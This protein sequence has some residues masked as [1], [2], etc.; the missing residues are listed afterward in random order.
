MSDY[1]APLSLLAILCAIAL[2]FK[3]NINTGLIALGMALPLGQ[4]LGG[5]SAREIIALW[6]IQ[7]FVTLCGV[8]LLFSIAKANDTLS[9]L[10]HYAISLVGGRARF[11][12]WMIFFLA[13][14]L[15]AIGPGNIAVCA[16]LGSIAMAVADE[17][18]IP[19]IMMG[20][21]LVSGANAGGLSPFAPTGI[22][23]NTLAFETMGI[24]TGFYLWLSNA[25]A[26]LLWVLFLFPF[27]GGFKLS[28]ARMQSN[29]E[30]PSF[31]AK[32]GFTL[33]AIVV[34]I[35]LV[36]GLKMDVGLCSFSLSALLLLGK[37]A[38]EKPSIA[39]IPWGTLLLVSGTAILIE[40]SARLGGISLITSALQRFMNPATA[41]PLY[42]FIAA[43]ISFFASSSGVV[44]PMLIRTLPELLLQLPELSGVV[45]TGTI[46]Y[47]AHIMT[48]SPFSTLG[49]LAAASLSDKS[50]RQLFFKQQL[51]LS[52]IGVPFAVLVALLLSRLLPIV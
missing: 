38:P 27:L 25:L 10:A 2:S 39:G 7:L 20:V 9:L 49:A 41:A 35:V 43:I 42:A 50:D 22:I 4:L 28:M 13:A 12:P 29:E 23:G 51:R 8:T 14:L 45:L 6:P 52:L 18:E 44:M 17:L 47:A 33:L 16:L 3:R 48:I 34:L 31:S 21:F 11:I 40:I 36:M 30:R 19:P 1:A 32:Q 5:L 15:A 24:D 46:A 26:S 37:A